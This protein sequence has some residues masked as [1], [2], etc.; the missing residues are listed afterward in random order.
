MLGEWVLKKVPPMNGVMKFGDKRNIS[1]IFIGP[2]MILKLFGDV[3]YKL[4]FPLYL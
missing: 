1:L 2:F 4:Y 3:A